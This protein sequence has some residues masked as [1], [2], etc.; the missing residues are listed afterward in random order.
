MKNILLIGLGRF[1][2]HIALQLNKLGHEVMAVD[3]NEERV[4]EILPIV[5]NAQIGDS[6]NT[7]FLKSLGIGNFDVCIVTIGGNFQN[8][9]ETTS[10]LKELGAKL[11]VS[12]AER[13]VQE[14]FLLRNGADEVVYPEK[15]VANWAAIRYTA[16]HIRDYIEVDDAHAIFEVEVPEEWIGKTVGELD[17]RRKYSINIM[18][19]K[20]N[21]K[22]NMAVS[23][24]TV[25]T[26]NITL[27]VLGAYKEL[28]K[29]F[30]I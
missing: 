29:C 16:D 28:Q 15:Q 5:T 11:V 21:G 12:R 7:E 1:G 25:L 30:R 6:T 10:L 4:N 26:G 14:K 23:P 3:S 24:E 27:L 22:I 9:L 2:R 17:I 20:E 18:A 13:D 8:S 19:T